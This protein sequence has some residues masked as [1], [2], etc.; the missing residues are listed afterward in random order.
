MTLGEVEGILGKGTEKSGL[1]GAVG[2]LSGSAKIMTWGDEQK[3]IT[4][5]FA[6]D[7]VIRIVA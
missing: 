6:N 5:T 7:K 2:N 3:S 1:S 4:I